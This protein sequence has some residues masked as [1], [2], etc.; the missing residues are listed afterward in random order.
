MSA[1]LLSATA[2]P[3]I[4]RSSLTRLG[5]LVAVA[6]ALAACGGS[7]A[8]LS[9]VGSSVGGDANGA[10]AAAPGAAP[11]EAGGKADQQGNGPVD[12][13]LLGGPLI[14]RTGQLTLEVTV[15]DDALVDADA[16][17]TAAGG[18][19]AG[20]Q[21][22]GDGDS[23]S[24]TVTYR[25]PAERWVATLAALRAVGTKVL[26]EQTASE[27]VTSQVVDLGA[28]L[29]NL[30]AT[31]SALQAIMAKA[32]KIP[33]ILEVQAQLSGVRQEIEQLTAQK[34]SLEKQAALATLTVGFSLPPTV[35]VAQVQQGWNPAD[36]VDRAAATLVGIGQ[37]VANAAI[38]VAIVFLPLALVL[39]IAFGIAWLV[40]RRLRPRS[41]PPTAPTPAAPMDAPAA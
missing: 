2:G 9:T 5:A 38:W 23:A 39:G 24:A 17:V 21:R 18:Y 10:P 40:A 4:A 13:N 7:S 14:V 12:A 3:R 33:D 11:A 15:L 19:V 6:F 31:E 26:S 35:A 27:E 34:Q 16:A 37:A 30:R 41:T 22:Q 20:S 29:A 36:E 32:T 1:P 28:R 25:I 8:I